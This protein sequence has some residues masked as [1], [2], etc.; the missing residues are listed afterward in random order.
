MTCFCNETAEMA[1]NQ[2]FCSCPPQSRNKNVIKSH[3]FS[4]WKKKK[5]SNEE[6]KHSK[7][8]REVQQLSGRTWREK[9]KPNA[10]VTSNKHHICCRMTGS[11]EAQA[12]SGTHCLDARASN[13]ARDTVTTCLWTNVDRN[14]RGKIHSD[15]LVDFPHLHVTKQ[16][17]LSA[18]VSSGS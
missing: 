13:E 16:T 18:F 7:R 8:W 2:P 14:K 5:Q 11:F 17:I 1:T 6:E 9:K 4:K 10:T 3:A 12:T 15:W